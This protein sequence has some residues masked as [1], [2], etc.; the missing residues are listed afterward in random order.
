MD[1]DGYDPEKYVDV[2]MS[3]I[4]P[5]DLVALYNTVCRSLEISPGQSRILAEGI[6]AWA[7][8]ERYCGNCGT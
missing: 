8:K 6:L 5:E 2:L 4:K 1:D 3:V 7:R